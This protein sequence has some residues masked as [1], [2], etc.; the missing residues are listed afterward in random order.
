MEIQTVLYIYLSPSHLGGQ[1]RQAVEFDHRLPLRQAI[2]F[3][4]LKSNGI[5][6][7]PLQAMYSL[8]LSQHQKTVGI[9]GTYAG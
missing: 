5:L 9:G 3:D 4:D 6:K 2:G 7:E 8:S 1:P